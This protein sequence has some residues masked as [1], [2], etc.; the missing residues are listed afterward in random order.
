MVS[1]C[2]LCSGILR[3]D[4]LS[5]VLEGLKERFEVAKARLTAAQKRNAETVAELAAATTEHN[6]WYHA[7]NLETKEQERLAAEANKKQMPLPEI[8]IQPRPITARE[9]NTS[10]PSE[11][12]TDSTVS[13]ESPKQTEIVRDALRLHP[14]GMTPADIWEKHKKEISSRPYL[15][16]I[17]KRLRDKDEVALRRGKY[18]F[19]PKPV[20]PKTGA[21]MEV[22]TIQ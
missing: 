10:G 19:K 11:S 1:E 8:L 2:V 4:E 16:S 14:T 5:D 3:G 18:I 15:Y 7:V 20:E 13:Q 9:A 22:H 21:G 17:L 6:I 12:Q